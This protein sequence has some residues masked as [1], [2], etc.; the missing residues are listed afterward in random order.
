MIP[1]SSCQ[2]IANTPLEKNPF[3]GNVDAIRRF[4]PGTYRVVCPLP[5]NNIEMAGRGTD[6]DISRFRVTYRDTDGS[7]PRG[8]CWSSCSASPRG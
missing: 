3:K 4:T 6:N 1:A 2:V 7:T 8:R 5:V